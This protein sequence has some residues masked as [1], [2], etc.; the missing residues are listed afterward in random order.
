MSSGISPAVEEALCLVK[1]ELDQRELSVLRDISSSWGGPSLQR[2]FSLD[3]WFELFKALGGF[4]PH[5]CFCLFAQLFWTISLP[6]TP[7][8]AWLGVDKSRLAFAVW[9][10]V[11]RAFLVG[12]QWRICL[13]IQEAW[14]WSLGQE[15]PLEKE[16]A[17]HS[18]ILAWR[19]LW[20]EEPGGL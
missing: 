13:P 10:V 20:T 18:S 14:V 17:T 8:T 4:L 5:L 7:L 19:I 2:G 3:N 16:L 1:V 6:L 15:D 11:N 9:Y 12:Q